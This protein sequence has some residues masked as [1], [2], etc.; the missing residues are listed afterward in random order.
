M[1]ATENRSLLLSHQTM[2][3]LTAIALLV[4][5]F[6]SIV[7]P[8]AVMA[9]DEDV[10]VPVCCRRHG[11]KG[12]RCA[13]MAAFLSQRLAGQ[14]F[15]AVPASCPDSQAM[16]PAASQSGVGLP[17]NAAS[18]AIFVPHFMPLSWTAQRARS[19]EDSITRKRGPPAL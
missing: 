7:P 14:Y 8:R 13:T 15:R 4:L 1:G 5:T 10:S 11:G 9:E 6:A 12:H 17:V 19:G 2:R 3:R 18:S 16:A